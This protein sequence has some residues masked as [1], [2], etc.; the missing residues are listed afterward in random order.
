MDAGKTYTMLGV[1]DWPQ[2]LGVIPSAISWIYQLIDDRKRTTGSRY[3]VRVSAVEITGK[4]E[5]IKDLLADVTVNGKN[6]M[7][8]INI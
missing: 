8:V 7:N 1:D 4:T 2:N 5:K 6:V 3:S